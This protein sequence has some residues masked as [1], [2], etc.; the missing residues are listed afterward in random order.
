[1]AGVGGIGSLAYAGRAYL[2]SKKSLIDAL[3]K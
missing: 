1:M 3:R 2:R